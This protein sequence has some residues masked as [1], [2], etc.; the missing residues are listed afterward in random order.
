VHLVI[1]WVTVIVFLCWFYR[2]YANLSGLGARGLTYTPGW[3]VGFWF[4][5]FL[6]LVRPVQIA[7]EIWRNS[8]PAEATGDGISRATPGNSILIGFWWTIWLIGNVISYVSVRM[9]WEART[10]ET[11]K[12]AT[13]AGMLAEVLTVL[14]ALLALAVVIAIDARQ[15]A[16]ALGI[17]GGL[18]GGPDE[19]APEEYG[20]EE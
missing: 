5:P 15:T 7:Q 11:F 20:P 18:R 6:N 16:C 17:H 10:P 3:A 12:A 8:D 14:A 1:Y 2:V 13:A 4:V 9:S 19:Y